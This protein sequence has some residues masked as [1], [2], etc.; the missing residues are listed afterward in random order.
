[1]GEWQ[2]G[3]L[4]LSGKYILDESNRRGA[5]LPPW[6]ERPS[7]MVSLL[8]MLE[9]SASDY[10]E[11]SYQLGLMMATFK[12][13]DLTSGKGGIIDKLLGDCARLG[14]TV[15]R[16]QIALMVL[17]FVDVNPGKAKREGEYLHI[18]EAS[19]D[20][21]RFCHHIESIYSILKSELRSIIFR[22]IPKEKAKFCDPKWLTDTVLFKKYPDTIDE[23]QRAGRCFAYGENTACIFHLMRVTEFYLIK[24]A[25]SLS[26]SFNPINWGAIGQHITKEMEKKYQ[27]KTIDWRQ[28][29]PLY[30]E[31]LTDIQALSRAHR[32]PALHDIDKKYDEREASNML[33]IIEGFAIHVANKL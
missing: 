22:A 2:C 25:T 21:G 15:T 8:D 4:T 27:D 1:V 23:F 13:Q 14:L 31:I 33:T 28:S 7:G 29:E 5:Q 20:A 9:F 24:V 30:A 32:N 18:K 26:V 17:E 3:G 19:L 16:D 6:E 10:V 12:R 11:L